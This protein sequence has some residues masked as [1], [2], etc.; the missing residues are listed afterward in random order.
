MKKINKNEFLVT[1]KIAKINE[2]IVLE[3]G[4]RIEVLK[5]K[6]KVVSKDFPKDVLM[7][8]SD[9]ATEPEY[10]YHRSINSNEDWKYNKLLDYALNDKKLYPNIIQGFEDDLEDAKT[11]KRPVPSDAEIIKD[12]P[13]QIRL[14]KSIY[15]K[16]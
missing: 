12:Y 13:K 16:L 14:L 1:E 8:F 11:T 4:D 5:E 6:Y 2:E 3:A 10:W 15:K 7:S 9:I